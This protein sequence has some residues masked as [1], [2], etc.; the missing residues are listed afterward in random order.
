MVGLAPL[1]RMMWLRRSGFSASGFL[2]TLEGRVRVE[3][4]RKWASWQAVWEG[5]R[6]QRSFG[7]QRHV[8]RVRVEKGGNRA[9]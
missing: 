3:E 7:V 8:D 5:G 4:G 1:A 6:G 2:R 9:T